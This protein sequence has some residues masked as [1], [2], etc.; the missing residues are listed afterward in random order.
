LPTADPE[1]IRQE[2][3][4]YGLL[5]EEWGGEYYNGYIITAKQNYNIDSLLEL[6][7]LKA[8]MM[9]LKANPNKKAEG[10]FVD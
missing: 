6:V 5:P 1:K 8:E 2:L 3:A 4:Q 10:V 9:E 7:Q